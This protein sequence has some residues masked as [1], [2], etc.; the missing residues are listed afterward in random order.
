MTSTPPQT[1]KRADLAGTE[2]AYT[3]RAIYATLATGL[4]GVLAAVYA[5]LA[6]T[7]QDTLSLIVAATMFACSHAGIR[8]PRA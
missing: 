8:R 4:T 2:R 5:S 6:F 3:N 7:H 1:E